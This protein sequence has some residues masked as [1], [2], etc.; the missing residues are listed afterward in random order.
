MG[1]LRRTAL[2][3]AILS[4]LGG[5]GGGVTSSEEPV[6]GSR[7]ALGEDGAAAVAVHEVP[8]EL[9]EDATLS[10]ARRRASDALD[11][12][13]AR[14]P[15]GAPPLAGASE[16]ELAT[17]GALSRDATPASMR[18]EWRRQVARAS[19]EALEAPRV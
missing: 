12:L 4:T 11:V 7:A 8:P 3:I 17:I 14:T 10:T 16:T 1:P 13:S 6:V 18:D 15:E 5:G 9:A 2:I 19:V